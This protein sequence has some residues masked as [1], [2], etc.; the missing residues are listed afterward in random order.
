MTVQITEEARKE[1]ANI[2]LEIFR[3]ATRLRNIHQQDDAEN[4]GQNDLLWQAS[5]LMHAAD[6]QLQN[7]LQLYPGGGQVPIEWQLKKSDRT[8]DGGTF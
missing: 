4:D 8:L 1:I 2:R 5:S 6:V 3:L 7:Y